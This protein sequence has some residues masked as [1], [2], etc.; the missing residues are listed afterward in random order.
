M[1]V[2]AR[3]NGHAGTAGPPLGT[4][5]PGTPAAQLPLT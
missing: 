3:G 4:P 2:W 1:R 5:A